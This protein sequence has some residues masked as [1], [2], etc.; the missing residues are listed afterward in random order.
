MTFL[1]TGR[2]V[3][4]R[5]TG[6]PVDV[7]FTPYILAAVKSSHIILPVPVTVTG[8]DISVQLIESTGAHPEGWTY[9]VDITRDGKYL[10][11][12][13][14]PANEGDI[15]LEAYIGL[16]IMGNGGELVRVIGP[17]GPQ[18]PAG[19]PGPTGPLGPAGPQGPPGPAGAP[20]PTG[21][22]G[23]AGPQGPPGPA[24]ATGPTGLTGPQGPAGVQGPAGPAGPTGATGPAGP[25]GEYGAWNGVIATQSGG[26][27]TT[28]ANMNGASYTGAP[29]VSFVVKPSG[30][31]MIYTFAIAAPN[32]TAYSLSIYPEIRTAANGGGTLVDTGQS[33]RGEMCA[34]YSPMPNAQ[35]VTAF[36]WVTSLTPGATYWVRLLCSAT[37]A[38]GKVVLSSVR[39]LY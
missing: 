34:F 22:L 36:K 11:T 32:S 37:E 9:R 12:F 23:P 3:D 16:K 26:T 39:V 1:V 6:L 38:N 19:A 28:T 31:I 15:N 21:P 13:N 33:P 29:Q 35:M 14:I 7:T 10:R 30:A 20:G 27:F 4:P 8:P 5:N 2:I 24:G 17:P 18:G 25:Q